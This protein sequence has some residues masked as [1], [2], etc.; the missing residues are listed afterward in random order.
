MTSIWLPPRV[1]E[2]GRRCVEIQRRADR[3]GG[4]QPRIHWVNGCPQGD[5]TTDG[6]SK[7]KHTLVSRDLGRREGRTQVFGSS[8]V[9]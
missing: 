8:A 6:I 7:Q 1:V 5:V 4:P 3:S 2:G 9:N